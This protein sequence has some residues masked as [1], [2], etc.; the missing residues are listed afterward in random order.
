M[1]NVKNAFDN[2]FH[3]KLLYNLRKWDINKKVIKWIESFLDGRLTIIIMSK[4][5]LHKYEIKTDIS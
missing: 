5:K 4:K 2:V 3:V 1:L